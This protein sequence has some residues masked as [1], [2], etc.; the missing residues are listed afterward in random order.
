MSWRK[1]RAEF[2]PGLPA[3]PYPSMAQTYRATRHTSHSKLQTFHLFNKLP[4]D[5]RHM[6]WKL[7][8]DLTKSVK[9]SA[10]RSPHDNFDD[11]LARNSFISLYPKPHPASHICWESR[12]LLSHKWEKHPY[13]RFDLQKRSA[14]PRYFWWNKNLTLV[15]DSSHELEEFELASRTD[16]V[17]Y[18]KGFNATNITAIAIKYS[19]MNELATEHEL[20]ASAIDF[21][22]LNRF[23]IVTDPH[24][25]NVQS[26]KTELQRILKEGVS[27]AFNRF[28]ALDPTCEAVPIIDPWWQNP[29]I[30]IMTEEEFA[31][32]L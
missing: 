1:F 19:Q 13:I 26:F 14:F 4:E 6:I 21:F 12:N 20:C 32:K 3:I 9:L 2:E 22:A 16:M 23:I 25:D 30:E 8:V 28:I 31:S 5:L 15:F 11:D 7:F 18:D 17:L 29:V 27:A 24:N 10:L